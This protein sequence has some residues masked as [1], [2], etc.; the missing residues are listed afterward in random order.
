MLRFIR[1]GQRWLVGGVIALV[2]GVFVL[3]IGLGQPLQG[4]AGGDV[5]RVDD[6][7]FDVRDHARAR[8]QQAQYLQQALGESYDP[9]RLGDQ[10]DSIAANVLIQRGILVTEAQRLGLRV[11]EAEMQEV[12]RPLFT[13]EE[14]R[15]DLEAYRRF[16]QYEYGT[17]SRYLD[18]LR[19]DLLVQKMLRLIDTSVQVSEREALE[20]LRHESE[21][22]RLAAV[23]LDTSEP[24]ADVEI[25]PEEVQQL[26]EEDPKRVKAA[27]ERRAAELRE[28]ERVRARHILIEVG[29]D[30]PPEKVEAARAR[31]EE[32]L[33]GL[34]EGEDF[35]GLA[36][37]LSDDAATKDDGGDLGLIQRGQMV[38]PFEEAAFQLEEGTLSEPVRTR[39]GFHVIRVD[40]H[41]PAKEPRLEEYREQI[42]RGL[43]ETEA[44]ERHAR[45][46]AER[47]AAAVR[48]G[49]TLESAA[50]DA[51]LSIHRT[52]LFQR[53]PDGFVP[54]VGASLELQNVAFSLSQDDPS[55]ARIFR[56]GSKLVLVQLLERQ[57]PGPEE[58][59]EQVDEKL[60]E[61]RGRK[62]ERLRSQWIQARRDELAEQGRLQVNLSLVRDGGPARGAPRPAPP[63]PF[64]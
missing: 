22:I 46:T 39:Y 58:L 61:L 42:A 8:E 19:T 52:P 36:A 13:N 7:H 47:L 51:E 3:F 21:E 28:P 18:A 34:R 45:E 35:A 50:R 49:E 30:A 57:V 41:L 55:P 16:V 63:A 9:S 56:V 11:S 38:R 23:A 24:P 37:E 44:A 15:F 26:L 5:V 6:L 33:A 48:E 43:L 59:Q 12:I 17:E 31:A 54:G 62:R 4:G 14:G 40:E 2:G 64:G 25:S 20:A 27:F 32:A 29:E 10:L 60:A 53:R 1:Q